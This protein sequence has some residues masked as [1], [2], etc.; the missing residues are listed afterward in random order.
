M[1]LSLAPTTY[2]YVYLSRK[3]YIASSQQLPVICETDR[4]VTWVILCYCKTVHLSRKPHQAKMAS[5]SV[6][7]DFSSFGWVNINLKEKWKQCGTDLC[8][9]MRLHEKTGYLSKFFSWNRKG[10]NI[11]NHTSL[12]SLLSTQ[13]L[14]QILVYSK[15]VV[16]QLEHVSDSTGSLMK[17]QMA[18]SHPQN[19]WL[20]VLNWGPRI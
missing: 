8:A 5:R 10:L 4:A 15:P 19:F 7:V 6:W 18:R 17:T 2:S 13:L 11:T 12:L 1:D 14:L 9:G 16:P 20:A 3:Q